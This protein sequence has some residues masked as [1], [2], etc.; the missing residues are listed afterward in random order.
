M[1]TVGGRGMRVFITG[2]TGL[3]GRRLAEAL[4]QRGDEPVVLSRRPGAGDVTGD[5]TQPGPWQDVLADCD[6]VVNLVGENIFEHRWTA[7]RKERLRTSRVLS[8]ERV[9]Q[10]LARRPRVPDGRPKVLVSASAVGYYGDRG[11]EELTEESPPGT[12]EMALLCRD[13]EAAAQAA[14]RSGVRVVRVRV[15]IVMDARGGALPPL[16][17]LFRWFLG[18]RLG[19]GQQWMSWV[20]HADLTGLLLLALDNRGVVGPLNGSAP[21]P[22]TNRDFARALGRA[23]GRPSLLPAPAFGLRLILGERATMLLH[24]QRVLPRRSLELGYGFRF[25]DVEGALRDA[26]EQP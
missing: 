13:W 23:L 10:A 5:P 25:P 17:R 6:A 1:L 9:C 21:N 2:G 12:D 3:V 22:V 24:G 14:E 15:G 26:L 7:A 16:R 19:S 8:T 4:R 18:G 11:D 20:H